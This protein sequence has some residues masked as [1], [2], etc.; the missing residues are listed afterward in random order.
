MVFSVYI[1]QSNGQVGSCIKLVKHTMKK[2]LGTNND[3]NL[4]LL[5]IRST[6]VGPG[7]PSPTTLLHNRPIRGLMPRAYRMPN[8]Y[9]YNEDNLNTLKAHQDMLRKN[10]V[11]FKG[12]FLLFL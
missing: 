4:A 7:L 9:D 10:N 12:P 6:P 5:H 11:T 1:H 2:Y 8:N 3:V